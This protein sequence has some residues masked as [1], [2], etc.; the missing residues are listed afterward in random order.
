MDKIL[1]HIEDEIKLHI[2]S[3]YETDYNTA[4][5]ADDTETALNKMYDVGSYETLLQIKKYL[6]DNK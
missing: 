1:K 3:G 6:E 5:Y 2:N 4:W